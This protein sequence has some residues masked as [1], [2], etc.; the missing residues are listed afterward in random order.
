M[1]VVGL[2]F[3][4]GLDVYYHNPK[5]LE[6][7]LY[8]SMTVLSGVWL[9][10]NFLA[11]ELASASPELALVF[12]RLDFA[13]APFCFY[14]LFAFCHHFL[15]GEKLS[16]FEKV[17]RLLPL[18]LFVGLVFSNAVIRDVAIMEGKPQYQTGHW[19]GGYAGYLITLFALSIGTLVKKYDRFKGVRRRRV[20]YILI[21]LLVSVSIAV[22][23][24]LILEPLMELPTWVMRL[25]IYGVLVFVV[26]SAMA[27]GVVGRVKRRE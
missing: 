4:L 12:L 21:G 1:V 23:I 25:G 16:V 10:C 7:R 3:L 18:L 20:L 17:S 9:I 5:C 13:T 11:Y 24:N 27:M 8:A 6:R 19:W 15:S 2:V 26:M 22:G 14:Y